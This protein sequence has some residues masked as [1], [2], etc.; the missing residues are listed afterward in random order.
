[1]QYFENLAINLS[2]CIFYQLLEDVPEE[3]AVCELDCRKHQC[4]ERDWVRC[5]RRVSRL[6]STL[7]HA[8]E[9]DS[10]EVVLNGS[11]ARESLTRS[12][13]VYERLLVQWMGSAYLDRNAP[14][15]PVSRPFNASS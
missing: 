1:M 13:S 2:N 3:S 7:T 9:F 15:F 11:R 6:T 4:T 14:I 12:P 8:G 5:R 10:A